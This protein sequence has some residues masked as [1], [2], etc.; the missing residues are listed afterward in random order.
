MHFALASGGF[1]EAREHAG[2]AERVHAHDRP[3]SA[4]E[5]PREPVCVW[6]FRVWGLG[7]WGLRL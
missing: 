2:R 3:Q 4:L 6:G 1:V 5:M 7:V